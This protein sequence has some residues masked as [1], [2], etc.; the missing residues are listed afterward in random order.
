[1]E[2]PSHIWRSTVNELLPKPF[3]NEERYFS[4]TCCFTWSSSAS[5]S[6]RT[7][8][9]AAAFTAWLWENPLGSP[10][11]CLWYLSYA[12]FTRDTILA[13]LLRSQMPKSAKASKLKEHQKSQ[14]DF[15]VEDEFC[16][17]AN[18]HITLLIMHRNLKSYCLLKFHDY[19]TSQNLLQLKNPPS[20]VYI[21]RILSINN[22]NKINRCIQ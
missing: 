8:M 20:G 6:G 21:N 14:L 12:T 16:F 9:P 18:V 2:R 22:S 1:M 3:C 13:Q 11:P 15:C 7:P 19:K 10:H 4:Q 5:G 17:I